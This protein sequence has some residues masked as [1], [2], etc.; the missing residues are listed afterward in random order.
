MDTRNNKLSLPVLS[1]FPWSTAGLV[2]VRDVLIYEL[3]RA[4]QSDESLAIEEPDSCRLMDT[5][6]VAFVPTSQV[7]LKTADPSTRNNDEGGL[8]D[9]PATMPQYQ[10]SIEITKYDKNNT[11]TCHLR[12][13]HEG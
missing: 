1:V 6:M 12:C 10:K 8:A 7:P 9:I 5:C 13:S 3:L 11:L 2:L 4:S